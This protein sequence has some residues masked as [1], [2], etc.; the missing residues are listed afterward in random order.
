VTDETASNSG[1]AG[2][3]TTAATDRGEWTATTNGK[4]P[5]ALLHFAV[6]TA[7]LLR[8]HVLLLHALRY[9][10]L[11]LATQLLLQCCEVSYIVIDLR[12]YAY[13]QCLC[14]VNNRYA[15]QCERL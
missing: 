10:A 4:H 6:C 15:Q 9:T 11:M 3:D 14:T 2:T 5:L 1:T 8:V 13:I 12:A 7:A